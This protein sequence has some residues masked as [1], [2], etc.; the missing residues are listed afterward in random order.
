MSRISF[1]SLLKKSSLSRSTVRF[2][3]PSARSLIS[4]GPSS[5]ITTNGG[6]TKTEN[7]FDGSFFFSWSTWLANSASVKAADNV[8]LAAVELGVDE[9]KLVDGGLFESDAVLLTERG[10]L[11]EPTPDRASPQA[12]TSVRASAMTITRMTVRIVSRAMSKE[13]FA[14]RLMYLLPLSVSRTESNPQQRVCQKLKN[15]VREIEMGARILGA[16]ASSPARFR[17]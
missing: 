3:V 4:D 13:S 5:P 17:G 9:V 16:W 2:T 11:F 14:S 6:C 7:S 12:E 10:L 8:V 15:F 1:G